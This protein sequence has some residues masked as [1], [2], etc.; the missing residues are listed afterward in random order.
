M[1][2]FLRKILL[3]LLLLL[4]GSYGCMAQGE[5]NIWINNYAFVSMDFNGGPDPAF[6]TVPLSA[7]WSGPFAR[8]ASVCDASGRLLFYTNGRDVFTGSGAT[9][10]QD[11]TSPV[12]PDYYF[13]TPVLIMQQPG[14]AG[15]YYIFTL[16]SDSVDH[17]TLYYS[18]VDMSMESGEGAIDPSERNVKIKDDL[19]QSFLV[20][21]HNE[22]C[23]MWVS[24][25]AKD[26]NTFMSFPVTAAG[27]GQPVY[28]VAGP[29]IAT[30]PSPHLFGLSSFMIGKRSKDDRKVS[31]VTT[32]L[33]AGGEYVS[34]TLQILSFDRHTG[35]FS[36]DLTLF[37]NVTD[38]Y[39]LNLYPCCFSPDGSKLYTTDHY[40]GNNPGKIIQYDLSLVSEIAV[41]QSKTVIDTLPPPTSLH[42]SYIT[43]MRLGPD[44]RIYIASLTPTPPARINRPNLAGPD[45]S[46]QRGLTPLLS[47]F[48]VPVLFA[49]EAMIPP[50]TGKRDLLGN[51]TTVCRGQTLL[52]EL[53]EF[54]GH[55]Y[56]WQD[57]STGSF[58]SVQKEG[59]YT[60]QLQSPCGAY[61]DSVHITYQSCNCST[62]KAPTAFSPNGDG[63]NDEFLPLN[64]CGTDIRSYDLNIYNRWGQQVFASSDGHKGWDGRY[65]NQPADVGTYFYVV[66]IVPQQNDR[67]P[68]FQKGDFVLL[69]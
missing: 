40:S 68:L 5:N 15:R 20:A 33:N 1:K 36:D 49:E 55:L 64:D 28:S 8:T 16:A 62:V 23:H 29:L 42:E 38:A 6:G 7:G 61:T 35:R 27:I 43:D 47:S 13:L 50:Q 19:M 37:Q 67:T 12:V 54:E 53:P 9:I 14:N 60:V 59:T 39:R 18:V 34:R 10:Q 41:R 51:D 63:L 21:A 3:Q 4:L 22:D 32:E 58:Y 30:P 25:R 44:D 11:S 57:G 24:V 45:C 69:R 66:R 46:V 2:S 56:T 31:L 65:S 17:A 26:T 52:L 48:S